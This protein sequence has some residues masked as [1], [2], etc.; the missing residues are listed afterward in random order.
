M[1]LQIDPSVNVLGGTLEPCSRAPMTGFF[2]NGSCDTCAQDQ[3]SHTVCALM[4]AEFLAYSKYL[5]NDLSTPR[6]EFG[7]PGLKPGDRWCLCASR[8]LQ[9]HHEGV[10]PKIV[11]T[12]THLRALDIVP[13]AILRNCAVDQA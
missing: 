13:L 11:L 5:G 1:P 8:F 12:A 3:G 10:A 6:P 7:F 2:R 4:T 9:A